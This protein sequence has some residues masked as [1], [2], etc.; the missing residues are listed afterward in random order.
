MVR[1]HQALPALWGTAM[2]DNLST[3]QFDEFADDL[4]AERTARPLF[5]VGTSKVENLLFLVLRQHL[6]PKKTRPNDQDELLEGDRPL[7]TFSARIKLCYRL[8]LIDETLYQAL[9]QLRN[10]RNQCAHSIIFDVTSPPIREREAALR[11]SFAQRKSYRLTKE[12]YF[13]SKK[14]TA[15]E[16]LQCVLLT[17]CALLEVILDSTTVTRGNKHA[18][19]IASR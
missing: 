4:L 13:G 5:I 15:T 11:K 3:D 17:L 14:L 12:R 9:E 10:I 18:L 19:R 16:E 1:C 2:R 7:A 6:L 8:G